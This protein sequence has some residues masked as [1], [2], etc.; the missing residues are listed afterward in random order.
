LEIVDARSLFVFTQFSNPFGIPDPIPTFFQLISI[1]SDQGSSTSIDPAQTHM[2]LLVSIK[3]G[4]LPIFVFVATG[5]HG[6]TGTGIQEEGTKTGTGPAIFQFMGL[7]GDLHC[8]NAGILTKRR[9][10]VSLHY[11]RILA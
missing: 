9:T 11:R 3:A 10:S 1:F 5:F 2:V 6:I 7:A 8:P 4:L